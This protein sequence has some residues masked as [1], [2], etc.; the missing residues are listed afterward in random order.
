LTIEL[1]HEELKRHR[2]IILATINYS[3]EKSGITLKIDGKDI[4]ETHYQKLKQQTEKYFQDGKLEKLQLTLAKVLEYPLGR[5]DLNFDN[6][7]KE[8]TGYEINIF[9][10]IKE[11][12]DSIIK[13]NRIKNEKELYEVWCVIQMLRQESPGGNKI[14]VLDNLRLDFIKRRNKKQK[15]KEDIYNPK[16]LSLIHSPNKKFKLIIWEHE[17][18]GEYGTTTVFV[19][20]KNSGAGIYGVQ[21]VNLNI[22]AYWKDDN[23]II[24]ESKKKYKTLSKHYQIQFDN[25]VIDVNLIEA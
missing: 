20:G 2:D 17:K 9:Q 8:K 6:Y 15:P 16:E 11:R 7:I 1:N 5:V 25:D 22:K 3:I 18:N 21:R 12:V 10:N 19:S 24:I 23:T 4:R 13:Q 14:I